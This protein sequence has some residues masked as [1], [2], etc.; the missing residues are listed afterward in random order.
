MTHTKGSLCTPA[1]FKPSW[2]SPWFELPSPTVAVAI[3]FLPSIFIA[4]AA[5]TAWGI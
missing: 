4:K 5:P 3:F 2:K 1:K